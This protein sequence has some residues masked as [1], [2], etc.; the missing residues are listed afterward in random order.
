[1]NEYRVAYFLTHSL[2]LWYVRR[3]ICTV[4]VSRWK[5]YTDWHLQSTWDLLSRLSLV[6][7]FV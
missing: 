6:G 2:L 3:T 7:T 1:M 5:F 4:R